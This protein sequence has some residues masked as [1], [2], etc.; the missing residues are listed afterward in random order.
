[1][2][3][4]V[5]LSAVAWL[6]VLLLPWRPWSTRERIDAEASGRR[7]SA[8]R[9]AP[10]VTVLIPARNEA[11][12]IGRTLAALREQRADLQVVVIDDQSTDDTAALAESAFQGGRLTVLRG[13]ALPAG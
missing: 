11:E 6:G 8:E 3:L 4:L 7:E 5:L 12:G 2:L 1:M 10:S 13:A 9:P